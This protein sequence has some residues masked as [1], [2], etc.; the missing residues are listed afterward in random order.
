MKQN[1]RRATRSPLFHVTEEGGRIDGPNPGLVGDCSGLV[2]DCSDLR[3]Y[4]F[5]LRGYCS[6]LMGDCSGLKGDCTDL[7]GDCSGLVGNLDKCELTQKER[8]KGV[9]VTELVS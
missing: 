8:Q 7:G 4:C 1:L 3:G 9:L 2:G 5:N 6:D